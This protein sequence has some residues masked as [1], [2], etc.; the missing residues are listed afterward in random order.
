MRTE[1]MGWTIISLTT[2]FRVA[3]MLCSIFIAS[4]THTS[5]PAITDSPG[6]T[7]IEITRP[8]K[9][10]RI[11]LSEAEAE[12]PRVGGGGTIMPGVCVRP[13]RVRGA[14]AVGRPSTSTKKVS[15]STV[16]WT[17]DWVSSPTSTSYQLSPTLIRRVVTANPCSPMF[18]KEVVPGARRRARD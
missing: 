7:R 8:D 13:R 18:G 6:R 4:T 11:M 9:G 12:E 14:G 10:D 17:G 5:W 2:P 16:T 15:P 3:R 1:S